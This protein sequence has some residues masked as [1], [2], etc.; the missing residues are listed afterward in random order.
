MITYYFSWGIQIEIMIR[1][2][3]N[4][5]LRDYISTCEYYD[6][7]S[8]FLHLRVTIGKVEDNIHNR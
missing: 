8:H 7:Y 2:S 5:I 4:I 6:A 3:N 1:I